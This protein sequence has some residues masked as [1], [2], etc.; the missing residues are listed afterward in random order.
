MHELDRVAALQLDIF[1]PQEDPPQLL[2][3]LR[4]LVEA[5]QRAVRAGQRKRLVDELVT[6]VEKGS[7]RERTKRRK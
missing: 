3:M 7:E 2:P 6:R 1:A 5:N 4:S